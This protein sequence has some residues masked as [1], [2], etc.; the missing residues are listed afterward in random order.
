MMDFKKGDYINLGSGGCSCIEKIINIK[1][2]EIYI[3]TYISCNSGKSGCRVG[4]TFTNI[5]PVDC[6]N[7][8]LMNHINTPLYNAM[9]N[10]K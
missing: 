5:Y 1:D 6:D 3:K 2:N 4:N 9:E 7:Y 10:I 8:I